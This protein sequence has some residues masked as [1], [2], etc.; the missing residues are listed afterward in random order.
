MVSDIHYLLDTNIVSEGSKIAPNQK[1]ADKLDAF[2]GYCAVSTISW[3]EI[4]KGIKRLPSGKK[5][6]FLLAYAE[7]QISNVFDFIPYTKECADMQSEIFSRL[8]SVGKA[9]PYQDAQ[10]AATA[11]AFNLTLVTRNTKDF[12]SIAS[13]FPLKIENWFE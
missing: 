1:I 3:Y 7:E 13:C 6:D 12:E 10:I 8:E 2:A 11:L 5:K 9:V 4:Q